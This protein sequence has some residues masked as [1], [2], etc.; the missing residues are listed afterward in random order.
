M[1]VVPMRRK[2]NSDRV[3]YRAKEAEPIALVQAKR[4][5]W[6]RLLDSAEGYT[7]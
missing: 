2:Q 4:I 3:Q 1:M 5:P 6:K 7:V